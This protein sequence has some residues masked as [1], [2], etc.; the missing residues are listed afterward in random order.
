M[1]VSRRACLGQRL[2]RLEGRLEGQHKVRAGA[3]VQVSQREVAGREKGR[4]GEGGNHPGGD[5]LA[6][7]LGGRWW[8]PESTVGWGGY[9]DASHAC[10]HIQPPLT[11][12]SFYSGLLSNPRVLG[13]SAGL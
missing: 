3:G 4:Q 7:G 9:V 6:V 1:R 2:G 12:S 5:G 10:P 11:Q 8:G 13:L